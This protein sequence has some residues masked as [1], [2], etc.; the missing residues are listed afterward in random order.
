MDGLGLTTAGSLKGYCGYYVLERRGRTCRR[1]TPA[2]RP[3]G[4]GY[5]NGKNWMSGWMRGDRSW[6]SWTNV[7]NSTGA[8]PS[9][10]AVSPLPK[11]GR[12]RRKDQTRQGNE[13]DG[14]GRRRRYSYWKAPGLCEPER[15]HARRKDAE[16]CGCP[17]KGRW[18][19]E[20]KTGKTYRGQRVRQRP[21]AGTVGSQRHRTDKPAPAEQN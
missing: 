19:S 15:G 6:A 18:R 11:K 10:T 3:A 21:S 1:N 4:V 9:S 12:M 7:G 2:H 13:V 14:G 16:Q 20:A 17:S 5:V 8:K